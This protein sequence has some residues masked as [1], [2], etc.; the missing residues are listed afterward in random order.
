M[1][2]FGLSGGGGDP[3]PPGAAVAV[4][5]FGTLSLASSGY[6][7]ACSWSFPPPSSR[8]RRWI[9]LST[10]SRLRNS[11]RKEKYVLGFCKEAFIWERYAWRVEKGGVKE[12]E[13]RRS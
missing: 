13:I 9:A 4:A 5:A 2:A 8:I 10:G 1:E 12:G 3:V 7:G 6:D 11:I